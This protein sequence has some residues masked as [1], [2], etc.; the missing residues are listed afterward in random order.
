MLCCVV[1]NMWSLNNLKWSSCQLIHE[2]QS[3]KHQGIEIKFLCDLILTWFDTLL[4]CACCLCGL[5]L[6]FV[7]VC[8]S[9]CVFLFF[10]SS[11]HSSKY[12]DKTQ[13]I[14]RSF[15]P[16]QSIREKTT[17]RSGGF[18]SIKPPSEQQQQPFNVRD[19]ELILSLSLPVLFHHPPSQSLHQKLSQILAMRA[20]HSI[21]I[22][23][24]T[25]EQLLFQFNFNL[26]S[27]KYQ[28]SVLQEILVVDER[29]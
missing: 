15:G 14:G 27:G 5:P 19:V 10:L 4:C 9:P 3:Y 20:V 28:L 12:P 2:T 7:C 11:K 21:L 17:Q 29:Q 13:C 6:A 25:M 8:Q 24:F 1:T 22:F 23:F 26:W 18:C 16:G